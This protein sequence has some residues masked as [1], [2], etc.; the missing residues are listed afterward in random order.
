MIIGSG[1]AEWFDMVNWVALGCVAVML[2]APFVVP[3]IQNW[4][5]K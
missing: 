5:N 4:W 3:W 2:C 1:S